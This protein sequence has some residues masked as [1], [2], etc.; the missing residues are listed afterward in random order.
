[1]KKILFLFTLF[2]TSLSFGQSLEDS[3][4]AYPS[5]NYDT[6]YVL[7]HEYHLI[8]SLWEQPEYV[9]E[10]PVMVMVDSLEKYFRKEE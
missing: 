7:K 4:I 10:K 3:R 5:K 9:N 1:M 2:I 6:L 8:A